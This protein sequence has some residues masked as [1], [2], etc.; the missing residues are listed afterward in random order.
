MADISDHVFGSS[1]GEGSSSR[2]AGRL[3]EDSDNED[4]AANEHGDQAVLN[5]DP[6]N[7]GTENA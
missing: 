4:L 2:E 7:D 1:N 5:D 6:L 3:L